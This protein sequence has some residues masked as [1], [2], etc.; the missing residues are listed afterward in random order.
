MDDYSRNIDQH[1]IKAYLETIYQVRKPAI[2]IKIGHS[3]PELAEFLMDNSAFHWAIITAF[4]PKSVQKNQETNLKS[5][6]EL[7]KKLTENGYFFVDSLN[8]S[9][10]NNW[11]VEESFFIFDVNEKEAIGIAKD[12]QQNAIVAGHLGGMP[13]LVLCY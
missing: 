11:P 10:H 7:H 1:L 3:N 13:S 8:T 2:D 5:N 9:Q 6:L 4:N 12:F